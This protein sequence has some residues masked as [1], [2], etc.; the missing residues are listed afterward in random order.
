MNKLYKNA[1]LT[2]IY[3]AVFL[4]IK[5]RINLSKQ[6]KNNLEKKPIQRIY[7]IGTPCHGNL[8]DHA[9]VQAQRK[10]ILD[11]HKDKELIEISSDEYKYNPKLIKKYIKKSDIIVIDGGGNIGTLWPTENDRMRRIIKDFEDNKIV[12]F[13]NTCFYSNDKILKED[14]SIYQKAK[15]LTVFL[16]D[17]KSFNFFKENFVGV[18]TLFA[19]DIVLYLED[20]NLSFKRQGALAVFRSDI[21]GILSIEDKE[22]IINALKEKNI[23]VKNTDTVL[24]FPIFKNSRQKL[25]NEKLEDCA[26]SKLVITDRLHGMI[27]A[28]ITKTPCLAIDNTS[29]KVSGVYEWIKHLDYIKVCFTASEIIDNIQKFYEK[30]DCEYN[31]E[32]LKKE[33]EILANELN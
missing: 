32:N 13:P 17:E 23:Q 15:K 29:K 21:E 10:L 14:I 25:L 19:P 5:D 30:E 16:R 3:R 26:K 4:R 31:N 8:G 24:D 33:Y 28:A 11:Y 27:F 20:I 1:V 2:R 18:K 7:L 22:N 6:F 9:I 12:V